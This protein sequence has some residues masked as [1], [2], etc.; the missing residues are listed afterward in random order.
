MDTAKQ[1]LEHFLLKL[2]GFATGEGYAC[3]LTQYLLAD[4]LWLS[5]VHVGRVLPDLR[6]ADM[7]AFQHGKAR[8]LDFDRNCL[9]NDGPLLT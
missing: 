4:A 5:A 1:R 7:V 3:T 2:V 9:N 8:F 6:A